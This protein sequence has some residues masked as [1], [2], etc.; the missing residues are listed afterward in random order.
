MTPH[1]VL[2]GGVPHALAS[3]DVHDHRRVEAT[4]E[5]EGVLHRVLIVTVDR[6]DVLQAQIGEHHLG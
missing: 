6:A 2:G 4:C 5:A 1:V 3:D